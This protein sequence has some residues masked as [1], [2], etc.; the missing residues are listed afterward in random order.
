MLPSWQVGRDR[1]R[2]RARRQVFSRA[3][4]ARAGAHTRTIRAHVKRKVQEN[5][6]SGRTGRAGSADDARL[7]PVGHVRSVSVPTSP[8]SGEGRGRQSGS[9]GRMDGRAGVLN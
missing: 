3:T 9:L 8:A 6:R 4:N 2:D 7:S 1:L 5:E